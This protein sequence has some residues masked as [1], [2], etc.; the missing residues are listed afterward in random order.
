MNKT[1]LKSLIITAELPYPPASGGSLRV[2]GLLRGLHAA[3][4]ELT[5][6][7]CQQGEVLPPLAQLAHVVTVPVAPKRRIQRLITL[8]TSTQPD[9]AARLYDKRVLQCVVDLLSTEDFNLVQVEG[10]ET[11]CYLEPLR[12]RFPS[13]KL[14]FDTFNAEA[15]MQRTIAQIDRQSLRGWPRA[16]YSYVQSRRIAAYERHLCQQADLVVTVSEED[17]NHLAAYGAQTPL[18]VVPSGITVNDYML[19]TQPRDDNLIV[20]TGKMDYRPNVDAVEWLVKEILP[21]VPQA[22]LKIVGQ[23]PTEQV[24]AL[25]SERVEITGRVPQVQPYLQAAAIYV[26]PLRMGSGTRLKLLEA[27]AC[28]CAIVATPLAASGLTS[29]VEQVMRIAEDAREFAAAVQS[30]LADP[31]ERARL[32]SAARNYVEQHYDWSVIVPRLL[33]AHRELMHG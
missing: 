28:G 2:W 9:I 14:V 7:C 22:Q 32:G 24:R 33:A 25:A 15:V 11:A 8:T 3:G 30:L 10:I 21:H 18:T 29:D 20:F 19:P 4:Y 26:A 13:L 31:Q 6:V 23:Q 5:V 17:R 27:M 1:R 16:L 12:E